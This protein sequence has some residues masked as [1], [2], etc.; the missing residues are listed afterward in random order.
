MKRYFCFDAVALSLATLMCILWSPS[1]SA[2]PVVTSDYA[3]CSS[4][5]HLLHWQK[6]PLLIYFDRSTCVPADDASRTWVPIAKRGFKEWVT[7]TNQAITFKIVD[8]PSLANLT[9]DFTPI[10]YLNGVEGS[11]GITGLI[12]SGTTLHRA[13][14]TIATGDATD[15]Q[16]QS[17]AA[18]EFGHALGIDGHSDRLGDL[19]YPSTVRVFT[20]D[21]KPVLAP[22][23]QVSSRDL[24]TLRLAYGFSDGHLASR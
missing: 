17:V 23:I 4:M 9:V 5:H 7:A 11:V 16:I 19:M 13:H 10:E 6:M 18:H 3:H 20:A 8:D 1:G 12:Y 14:M 15:S 21:M 22:P 24:N 2:D